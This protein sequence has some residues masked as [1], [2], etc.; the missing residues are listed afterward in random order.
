MNIVVL[1]GRLTRD[2][3][4][5]YSAGENPMAIARY[6]LAVDR[7]FKRDGDQQ[8]ADFI[9]CV[10][11]GRAAEFA[12]KYFHQGI[13]ITV[14]GRIQTGSYTNK[15]G[16]KVYTTEV[17]VENQEFAESKAASDASR[18]AYAQSGD[19]Q[20]GERQYGGQSRQQYGNPQPAPQRAPEAPEEGFMVIPDGIDEE[21][22]F[23]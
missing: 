22:P 16:N 10:A 4:V 15:E 11:F 20:Y 3:E 19:R 6:T 7:R 21:L 5:R 2:P 12:E 8:T 18:Q 17:V 9:P 1:M 23:N 14:N 13:R